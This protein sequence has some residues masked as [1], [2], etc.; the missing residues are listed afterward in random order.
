[1]KEPVRITLAICRD[2]DCH[3]LFSVDPDFISG[4]ALC[5][6]VMPCGHKLGKLILNA[7]ALR[8]ALEQKGGGGR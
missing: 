2:K 8:Q 4:A 6:P 7:T 1:M 3:F 5:S